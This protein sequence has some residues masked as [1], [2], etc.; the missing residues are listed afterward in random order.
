MGLS[1]DGRHDR[2]FLRRTIT[3]VHFK[4]KKVAPCYSAIP[5]KWSIY[6]SLNL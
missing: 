6:K 3:T 1:A 2:F 5:D 4:V